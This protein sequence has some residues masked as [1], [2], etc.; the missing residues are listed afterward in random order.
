MGDLFHQTNA[1][2]SATNQQIGTS[3]RDVSGQQV[4]G[5]AGSVTSGSGLALAQGANLNLRVTNQ[6]INKTELS[7]AAA[8]IN[9]ATNAN[10][11]ASHGQTQSFQNALSAPAESGPQASTLGGGSAPD[12]GG[13]GYGINPSQILWVGIAVVGVVLLLGMSKK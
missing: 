12:Y 13:N 9:S 11:S 1:N 2:Q 5:G 4:I 8:A 6:T 10:D 3:T 7:G